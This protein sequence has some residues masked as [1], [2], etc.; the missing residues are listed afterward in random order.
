MSDH[1][2]EDPN[3][4][5]GDLEATTAVLDALGPSLRDRAVWSEPPASLGD[6]IVAAIAAE[7][8]T[9][10]APPATADLDVQRRRRRPARWLGTVAAAAL[11]LAIGA[12][13]VLTREGDEQPG[14]QLAI[15]GTDLAPD[16]SATAVVDDT[17]AGVAIRLDLRGLEPAPEGQYYQG[18]LRNAEGELVSIGTFH[19]R[20]GDATITLWA[21]VEV[22]DYPTLTVTLQTEDE[23]TGSSGQVVLRGSLTD[24]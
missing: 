17:G 3:D 7:R 14:E 6:S 23:G 2:P 19:M 12:G 21:G 5:L 4:E 18:W 22:K 20:D 16:A 13:V 1:E 10:P 11:V 24:A 8:V 9:S 15:T